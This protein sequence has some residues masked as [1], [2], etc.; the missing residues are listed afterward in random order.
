MAFKSM[1][2]YGR[3]RKNSGGWRAEAEVSSVNGKGLDIRVNLPDEMA[4]MRSSFDEAIRAVIKRGYLSGSVKIE[5]AGER[6]GRSVAINMDLAREY[7]GKLRTA[8]KKLGL[9]DDLTLRSMLQWPGVIGGRETG[10]EETGVIRETALG[11]LKAALRELVQKRRREGAALEEHISGILTQLESCL[12]KLE[13]G[14]KQLPAKYKRDIKRKLREAGLKTSSGDSGLEREIILLA[15]RSDVSEEIVRLKSHMEQA[16][17]AIRSGKPAGRALDF[18][19]QEML[20]EINT[21][22]AKA[23]DRALAKQ[24]FRF[25]LDLDGLRE[26]VR[27]VE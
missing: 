17:K 4:P 11:A 22:G 24:V 9:R 7:A 23:G 26:Q 15:Q 14:A 25:K 8:G 21:L 6:E 20:R 19:C 27:N 2:G 13:K 5:R 3:G 12:E 18:L 1:T 10:D 16:R